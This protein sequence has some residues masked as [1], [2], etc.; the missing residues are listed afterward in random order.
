MV[1]DVVPLSRSSLERGCRRILGRSPNQEINRIRI[2]RVCDL[3]RETDLNLEQ[4]ARQSGFNTPQYLLQV[5]RKTM[6][7]TPGSYRRQ[8]R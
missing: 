5:F 4:I 6:R 2:D 1:L 8:Q 7:A 3:L